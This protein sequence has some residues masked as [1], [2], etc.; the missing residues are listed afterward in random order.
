MNLEELKKEASDLSAFPHNVKDTYLVVSLMDVLRFIDKATILATKV[1][2]ERCA[3]I[4]RQF[5]LPE[6]VIFG[7]GMNSRN[8]A[9]YGAAIASAI[10]NPLT[11]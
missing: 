5:E 9:L 3:E 11:N 7:E 1:E 8:S 6:G 2:R 10:E 4:A